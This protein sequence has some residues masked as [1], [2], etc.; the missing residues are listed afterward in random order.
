MQKILAFTILYSENA[1]ASKIMDLNP[2]VTMIV[3]RWI[4]DLILMLRRWGVLRLLGGRSCEAILH[5]HVPHHVPFLPYT[6]LPATGSNQEVHA[7]SQ[8]EPLNLLSF[9]N[10]LSVSQGNE[11]LI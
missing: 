9:V 4:L 6:S 11:K 2:K 3:G 5:R 8:C 1:W 7:A 10:K